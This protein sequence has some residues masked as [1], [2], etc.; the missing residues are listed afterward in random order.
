MIKEWMTRTVGPR[1][2][3]YRGVW[4]LARTAPTRGGYGRS[5]PE[6][7]RAYL[8]LV[9]ASGWIIRPA[10]MLAVL[11]YGTPRLVEFET[12]A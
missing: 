9:A 12:A 8:D 1:R 6:L 5:L 10:M 4:Q 11:G 2:I 7:R 3:T